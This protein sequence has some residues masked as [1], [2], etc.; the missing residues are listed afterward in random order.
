MSLTSVSKGA[1]YS[2]FL[3]GTC[4]NGFAVFG[5]DFVHYPSVLPLRDRTQCTGYDPLIMH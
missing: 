1:H 4:T 2:V 5:I 3:M